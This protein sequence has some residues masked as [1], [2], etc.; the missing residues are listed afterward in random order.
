[1]SSGFN[2]YTQEGNTF[3]REYAKQLGFGTDTER[4]IRV[5][6]G[7]MHALRDIIPINES[8]QLIAQ[9]PMLIKAI[10]VNGWTLRRLP[11]DI[12]HMGDFLELVRKHIGVSASGDL[13]EDD[14][15]AEQWV[16]LTFVYLRKYI[17]LGE[18]EDIRNTLPKDL[19]FMMY[20]N[21]MF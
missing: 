2:H 18:M 7:I 12:R 6:S 3:A 10:Y 21:L 9:L 8:L 4:A 15:L 19:K 5:F 17:S 11:T 1:M 14:E 13:G 20:S 16:Q